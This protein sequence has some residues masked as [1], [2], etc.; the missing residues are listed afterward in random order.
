MG[1][2]GQTEARPFGTSA[3]LAAAAAL[4]ASVAIP[5]H[6]FG[7]N[8]TITGTLVLVAVWAATHRGTDRY[9]GVFAGLTLVL[10]SLPAIRSA[11]WL[12][13]L[14]LLGALFV[15]SVGVAGARG[16]GG[17]LHQPAASSR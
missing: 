7:V 14:D 17:S 15:I 9:Y 11:T 8:L 16:V 2:E 13:A 10:L 6:P 1:L 12:V 5:G 4:V 3:L